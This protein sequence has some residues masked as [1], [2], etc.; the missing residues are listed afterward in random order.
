[1]RSCLRVLIGVLFLLTGICGAEAQSRLHVDNSSLA[2]AIDQ[3]GKRNKVVAVVLRE[4][5]LGNS[6][7]YDDIFPFQADSLTTLLLN[8][9]FIL[10]APVGQTANDIRG[11]YGVP[12]GGYGILFINS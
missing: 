4:R 7:L 12:A 1:M 11:R 5:V 8:S 10:S 9:R 3:A 2:S 6:A